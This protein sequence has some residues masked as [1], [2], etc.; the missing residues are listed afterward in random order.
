MNIIERNFETIMQEDRQGQQFDGENRQMVEY[1]I[2]S[3]RDVRELT[4]RIDQ[5][6]EQ[7]LGAGTIFTSGCSI[8][9]VGDT[10]WHANLGWHP[11]MLGGRSEPPVG[12]C[13]SGL[14]AGL[15]LDRLTRDT[16]CLRV[17]P[18]SHML[19]NAILDLLAPIHLDIP[20]N[21][22]ANGRIERFGI[23]PREVPGHTIESEPGDVIFFNHEIWHASFGGNPIRRSISLSYKASPTTDREH[24][25]IQTCKRKERRDAE[26]AGMAS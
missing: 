10:G 7:L 9:N 24:E 18:G 21:F 14:C 25:Y 4:R 12:H 22:S 23:A 26:G 8:L 6:A 11:S 16:G 15:Y 19:P 17:F 3:H 13:Y 5:A 20:N 2:V 1:S